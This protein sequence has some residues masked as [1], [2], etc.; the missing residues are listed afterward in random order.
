[1]NRHWT[2]EDFL[3]SLYEIGPQDGHLDSCA[4]CRAR[5]ERFRQN[6][7]A[8]LAQPQ[9]PAGLLFR[10]RRQI[11]SRLAKDARRRV[12]MRWTP[13]IALAGVMLFAIL[14]RVPVP[15]QLPPAQKPEAAVV[16]RSDAQLMA[17]VYRSVYETEP[18]AVEAMRGL[19]EVK[20]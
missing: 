10:Q 1:M 15:S 3:N 8:V 19:F 20:Q 14:S 9:V 17:E 12:W 4:E 6:R 13:A 7:K 2:E 16:S 18:G 5:W 11:E